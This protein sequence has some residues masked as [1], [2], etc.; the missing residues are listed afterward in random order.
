MKKLL[1]DITKSIVE[2]SDKVGVEEE[3]ENDSGITILRLTVD[4]QDIGRIIGKEGKMI[5]A[6]R[7][8]IRVAARKQNKRIRIELNEPAKD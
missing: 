2:N 8:L 3:V 5:N 7:S 6:I 4:P 1:L